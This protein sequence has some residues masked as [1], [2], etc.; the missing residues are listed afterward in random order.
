MADCNL[1][2]LDLV[3]VEF[4]KSDSFLRN[5]TDFVNYNKAQKRMRIVGNHV[6]L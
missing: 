2:N 5:V 3:F 4:A 1:R 6:V